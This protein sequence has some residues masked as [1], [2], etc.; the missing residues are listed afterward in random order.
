MSA[1]LSLRVLGVPAPFLASVVALVLLTIFFSAWAVSAES[2]NSRAYTL[3]AS[4]DGFVLGPP[5]EP[6]PGLSGELHSLPV[7]EQ[8]AADSWWGGALLK[9]CPFH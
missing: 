9:A 7:S 5:S 1:V 4:A 2:A 6:G 3:P 8:T